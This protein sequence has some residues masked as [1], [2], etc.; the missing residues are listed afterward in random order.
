MSLSLSAFQNRE[1][2]FKN[3]NNYT[4]TC[5]DAPSRFQSS[6]P[7]SYLQITERAGSKQVQRSKTGMSSRSLKM[8]DIYLLVA[9]LVFGE[10][11]Y[12]SDNGNESMMD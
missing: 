5:V 1:E 10:Q 6:H 8:T 2:S 3:I 4:F 9:N 11:T 7:F 12:L